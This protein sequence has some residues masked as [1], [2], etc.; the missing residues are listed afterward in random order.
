M[1]SKNASSVLLRIGVVIAKHIFVSSAVI[2]SNIGTNFINDQHKRTFLESSQ[3]RNYFWKRKV[4]VLLWLLL[5]DAEMQRK[6]HLS[7]KIQNAELNSTCCW[8]KKRVSILSRKSLCRITI[9]RIRFQVFRRSV[10][11]MHITSKT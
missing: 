1:G 2:S 9:H 6:I 7:R 4:V 11:L 3:S 8:V 10:T 5:K